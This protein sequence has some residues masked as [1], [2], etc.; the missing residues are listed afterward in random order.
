MPKF[1]DDII[2]D[3]G[4]KLGVGVT[5]PN[6]A[7]HISGS[8]DMRGNTDQ[9]QDTNQ[10]YLNANNG[11]S[12]GTSNDLGPG[13]TWKPYYN[14]YSKRS[15]GILQI[16]EGNYFR[17]GLAFYTNNTAD[18][19]TD[20]SERMRI[21]MDGNVGIGTNN[22]QYALLQVNGTT[23]FQGASQI[24]GDLSL[25]GNVKDLN[26]A[27]SAFLNT[28]TRNTS[29]SEL[30]LEY[31]YVKSFNATSG[32]NIGIGTA[33]P[34]GKL[35]IKSSSAFGTAYNNYDS[36]YIDSG[37]VTAGN[38]NFGA[39]I[40][41]SRLGSAT[42]KKAAIVPVQGTSD[43][44]NLGLAF[45]TSPNSGYA[46]VVTEAMR[47]NYNGN[48][49]IGTNS[50]SFKLDVEGDIGMNGKLYH[51]GDHNTYIGFE[52]DNIKLRTGGVDALELDSSQNAAFSGLVK[53]TAASGFVL[54][55]AVGMSMSYYTDVSS[56]AWGI[57]SSN[58][59][60]DTI[61]STNLKINGS[62]DVVTNQAHAAIKGSGVV[63]TGNGHHAGAGAIAM[64]ALG[65]GTA[66]AGTSTA[67][68]NYSLLITDTAATFAGDILLADNK[69]LKIGDN[70]DL[71][72]YHNGSHSFIQDTGAGDLRLLGSSIKLQNTSET[73]ILTLAS[74]LSA[75][76]AGSV[77]VADYIHWDLNSGEYSGDPRAV[78]M[79]YSGGNYGSIGYNIGYTS[80]SNT[81]NR[82]FNDIPTRMDLYDGILLYSS[83][84]GSA[85]TSIAWTELL[86]CQTNNFEYKSNDIFYS[87]YAGTATFGGSVSAS[88]V[89][90]G[91]NKLDGSSDNFKIHADSGNVSGNST[92]EFYID[93]TEKAVISSSALTI[94]DSMVGKG[95]IEE[96]VGSR[97]ENLFS[98]GNG[99]LGNI[100]NMPGFTFDGSN[101]NNSPG[102]FKWT[103]TGTPFTSEFIPVDTGRKYKMQYDAKTEN[104]VGKYYGFTAC[105]DVDGNQIQAAHHMYRANTL[106][107]LAVDLVNGATTMT[108]TN[109]ANWNNAG[110]AGQSNHLR[111]LIIWNYT[112][113]FGY[114][115]PEETYSRNWYNQAWDPGDINFTTHVVTLRVAWAGGTVA[116]GTKVSNGSS[117]GT[118]KYN[119]MS[120]K[121][122]TTD[123]VRQSGYMD[124]VDYSGTNVYNKFP[125]GTAK[126]KLGWLM[127]YQNVQP[128]EVAWFT[129]IQV[130]VAASEDNE[131]RDAV[132]RATD[133]NTF[134]DADHT[135]LASTV[136]T[137]N[138]ALPKAGGTMTGNLVINTSTNH[139]IEITGT[140]S[141]YTAIAVQNT[142]TGDAGIYFDAMNGDLVGSNY[143]F[144]GQKNEGELQ[145]DIGTS[146]PNAIHRFTGGGVTITHN[147]GL[148]VKSTTNGGGAQIKFSDLSASNSYAQAGHIKYYHAD[149]SSYGSGNVF[150]IGG[151]EASMT[152][153][154]DGKLM[155]SEGI[156]SKPASG[157]GAGTRVDTNWNTAYTHSQAAHAPSNADATSSTNVVSALNGNLGTV[158]FGDAND[159]INIQGNLTVTGVTTMSGGTVINTTTN[160][161]I[162]DTTIFL[163]AG[164]TGSGAGGSTPANVADIGL[165]LDRGSH[166]NVYM[167]WDESEDE[168]IFVKTTS[169][170]S[171][172]AGAAT[173]GGTPGIVIDNEETDFLHV[174]VGSL[175]SVGV[176]TSGNSNVLTAGTA[177]SSFP[178]GL[179]N[180][181]VT[182]VSG[183]AGSVTNGV[184]TT[185]TQTIGGAKTFSGA[186]SIGSTLASNEYS[187]VTIQGRNSHM[188]SFGGQ[189]DHTL[190]LNCGSYYQAEVTITAHQTNGGTYNNI[191][192]RGIWSNNHTSH[193]WDELERVGSMTGNTITIT[194]GQN[195]STTASGQLAIVHDNTQGDSF[196]LFTVNVIEHFG[197]STHVIS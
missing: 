35:T 177:A 128:G 83:A 89:I 163:N 149:G 12:G 102:S 84:A 22:P 63:F 66:S 190:T 37:G 148:F 76:F 155:Y 175:E 170:G 81:H 130:N 142:G 194:N 125:P 112:N 188:F 123:W 126:V 193:H 97:G 90:L 160:T 108:L 64:Y 169:E 5:S 88:E 181:N 7:L 106:T 80:T 65:N 3:G 41:F 103:G 153:L 52:S 75:T 140:N 74:D 110:T 98:N 13:I 109:S 164:I 61:I 6:S 19:T 9:E 11:N 120:N 152:I 16:G 20:W 127:N 62:H 54:G 151:T 187:L 131:I 56:S 143:G 68:E 146:S 158:T 195:G 197:S 34:G 124:G 134:T 51:N 179:Q 136:T 104:G 156:Y 167:G 32:G 172:D 114:T 2:I 101:A 150:V 8:L 28:K 67:E 26:K 135:A 92:I 38:G 87:G 144:I 96:W 55:A 186:T 171:D 15:A 48:V 117:G 53:T 82:V 182:S 159:E 105:Y 165:I 45:F 118:Y 178:S 166:G 99:L 132:E 184:Y 174:K 14:T 94:A 111:S 77:S 4:A 49:G 70:P 46:D 113:S 183:N 119:I 50:P 58:N 29:G 129:N 180:S 196:G 100:V 145:Y 21:S 121:T 40:G 72:I 36:I 122:L 168:F 93:G 78:V 115:Y 23:L 31:D 33:S 60:G 154:A 176:I 141:T 192:I 147:D 133:S 157:T 18:A 71:Q 47:I 86:Q 43:S 25:R 10:L 91:Q 107:T 185:G 138:A 191:Y 137:A 1:L 57:F 17:S 85:G 39:G 42:Y 173:G 69:K 73:N 27:A 44:D 30:T 161:A 79:G 189:S 139:P 59:H 162:K 116:A 95:S 24:Q